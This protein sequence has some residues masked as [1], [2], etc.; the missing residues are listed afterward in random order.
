MRKW[1]TSPGG[2]KTIHIILWSQ[3]TMGDDSKNVWYTEL[4]TCMHPGDMMV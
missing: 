2:G 3:L 1:R 4:V